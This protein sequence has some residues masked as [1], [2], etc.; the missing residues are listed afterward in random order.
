M[1]CKRADRAMAAESEKRLFH[2]GFAG[3]AKIGLP[4]HLANR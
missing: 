3:V 1:G 4:F 2:L